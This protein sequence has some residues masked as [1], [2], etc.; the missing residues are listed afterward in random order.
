MSWASE[1]PLLLDTNVPMHHQVYSELKRQILDG[2]W[3]DRPGFPGEAELTTWF[4]IS[5]ITSRRAL[6]RLA[7]EGLV[8]RERGRRP[9]AVYEPV[10]PIEH[11]QAPV[12]YANG[13][14]PFK[15]VV[16][17]YGVEH[18]PAEACVAFSVPVGTR[19][20]T[21]RRLRVFEGRPHSICYNVQQIELGERLSLELV[22]TTSMPEAR[23]AV[24]CKGV[25][26][27]RRMEVALPGS[28]V[29]S[30]LGVSLQEPL[31]RYTYRSFDAEG[32][33][34]DWVRIFLHPNEPV[35]EETFQLVD[36][37]WEAP[38]LI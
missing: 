23:A 30:D 38:G 24:G 2:L 27:S 16:R 32:T 12:I 18:V 9:K 10:V 4:D 34:I 33:T 25:R 26:L 29:A 22:A 19:M 17:S 11:G 14:S 37:T 28:E 1:E 6:E 21:W 20:W 15:Y 7:R 8:R 5:P 3:V 35:P 36:G 31:R 13:P